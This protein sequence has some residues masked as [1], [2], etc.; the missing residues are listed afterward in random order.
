M[1]GTKWWVVWLLAG[2]LALAPMAPAEGAEDEAAEPV[3]VMI[4]G[5]YHLANPGRDVVNIEA[6]DVLA[7]R[8]QEELAVLTEALAQWSP[9]RVLVEQEAAGPS[10]HLPGYEDFSDEML[11]E[12]R[13]EIVQV[14]YRLAHRLGH[15]HVYGF[16]EQSGEGEPNYFPLGPVRAYAEERGEGQVIQ[17]IFAEVQAMAEEQAAM[18]S[19]QSLPESFL[20]HN[21]P[22]ELERMHGLAYYGLLQ[23]GD[24]DRQPGAELNA[25]W[26][27][28]NAKMFAKL[29]L[30]AE[31][32]D[33]V[34][35]L[36]GSG[37]AYWL[38]HF[39]ETTPGYD[40]VDVRPYLRA[41]A[42][43][44]EAGRNGESG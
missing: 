36:V 4:L 23:L 27:M 18:Q 7:P 10:L 6:D 25:Y 17:D 22:A 8:R 15:K 33:R 41:A 44:M 9:D 24:G 43:A 1:A 39:V 21:D 2:V 42:I 11:A 40:L 28:R 19:E 30:T 13:N 34:F 20:F 38:S 31:P 29:M 37:H 3:E 26:Y 16:D 12:D 32:G 5:V 14:G 35:V